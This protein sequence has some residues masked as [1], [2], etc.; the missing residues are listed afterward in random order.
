MVGDDDQSIYGWRGAT[1]GEPAR[2]SPRDYP[3]LK[4]VKLEQNYRSSVRILKAA[5]ALIANNPQAVRQAAVERARLRRPD[6]RAA[7]ARR[8]GTRPSAW[9]RELLAPQVRAPRPTSATTP[10]STA[11][12]TRRGV[13]ER[14]AARAAHALR[15]SGGQ[16]FFERAEIKRQSWP[17][18]ALI[19][20]PGRR[21]RLPARGQHAARARSAPTTL[22]LLGRYAAEHA[23]SACSP[24]VLASPAIDASHSRDR[25]LAPRRASPHWL[26]GTDRPRAGAKSRPSVA[27]RP[28]GRHRTTRTG[29]RTPAT[30]LRGRARRAWKTCWN[31]PAGSRLARQAGGR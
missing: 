18:C 16:S 28:A 27:A 25:Q 1:L 23:A 8:R 30:S 17:T 11:A 26:L 12:T 29:S 22:E 10:S 9:S 4:V 19:A 5:N 15:I 20:Q 21:R 7:G 2:S 31:W 14:G 13:F 24:A 6:P 3:T